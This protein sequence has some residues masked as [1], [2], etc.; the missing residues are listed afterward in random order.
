MESK[1]P[2]IGKDEK[3]VLKATLT[4]K[5]VKIIKK[6]EFENDKDTVDEV[7]HIFRI[8]A[9]AIDAKVKDI[10]LYEQVSVT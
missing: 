3:G 2:A 4:W 5:N 1:I 8:I 7:N 6:C 10:H 9:D